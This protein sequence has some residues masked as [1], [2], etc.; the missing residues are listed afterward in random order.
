MAIQNV[1]SL[2]KNISHFTNVKSKNLVMVLAFL[3]IVIGLFFAHK[4]WVNYR[5]QSAQYDFAALMTEFETVSR[6]KDPQWS[7][8]LEKFE[9]EYQQHAHSSLLPYYLGYKVQI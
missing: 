7:A 5:E 4:L 3:L 2:F 6:E 8:L 1:S 9:T